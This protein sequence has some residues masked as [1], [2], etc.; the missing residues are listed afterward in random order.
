AGWSLSPSHAQ[1]PPYEPR[2]S[3]APNVNILEAALLSSIT[4]LVGILHY[5]PDVPVDGNKKA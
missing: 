1:R 2:F 3:R 5:S 4:Y